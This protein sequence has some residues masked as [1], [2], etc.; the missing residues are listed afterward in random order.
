[1]PA[2]TCTFRE[3]PVME[4]PLLLSLAQPEVIPWNRLIG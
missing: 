1:M 3:H 2:I 4:R